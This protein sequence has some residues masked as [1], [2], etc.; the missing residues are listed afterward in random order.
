MQILVDFLPVLAFVVAYWLADLHTA[1]FVIMA[2]MTIQV[3]LTWMIRRSVPK[4]LQFSTALVVGLGGLSLLL[5][6]D[7]IFKWKPT[8]LNWAFAVAFLGSQYIGQRP[9]VQRLMESAAPDQFK[10]QPGEWRQL[11]LMW[12]AYFLVA[13]AANI[14]VAYNFPENVWVNFKL[15]GLLGLTLIFMVLNGIWLSRREEK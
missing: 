9:L 4:M 15:F 2:A 13:G 6:N 14:Y 11:N 7:L 3:L 12:V 1:I 5:D 8:V 10:L